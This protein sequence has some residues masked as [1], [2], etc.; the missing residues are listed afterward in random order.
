MDISLV[1]RN[2]ML[3]FL[4]FFIFG[5]LIGSFLNAVLW[6][7]RE[8]IGLGGRSMCPQCR[9]KIAW[10]DNVP[11]LS[12]VFLRGKCRSCRAKISWRYPMVEGMTGLLFAV[13][14]MTFFSLEDVF[15]WMLTVFYLVSASVLVLIF[16]FDLDSMEIPN[17]LLWIGVGWS[18]P[19]LLVVN[20]ISFFP[21][22]S[23]WSLHLYSGVLAGLIAFLPLFLMAALS[24]ERW[25]GMGDGFLAFFLGLVVGWPHMMLALVLAFGMGAVVGILLI[26]FG[27]K[28]MKSQVPLGPFLIL[29]AFLALVLPAWFPVVSNAF[30]WYW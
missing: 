14:G 26:V 9:A 23:I 2:T 25:M 20:A 19:M 29:G 15:S 27:K 22:V 30:F 7:M 6:R 1:N 13:L 18:L 5:L 21:G 12:F 4:D 8:R 10:Y 16:L 11:I 3:V 17:V 24:G 28:G